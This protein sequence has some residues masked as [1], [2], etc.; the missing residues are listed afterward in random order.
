VAIVPL[1]PGLPVIIDAIKEIRRILQSP[2]QDLRQS[3]E[4][5]GPCSLAD[6]LL[7][8]VLRYVAS[9]VRD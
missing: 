5:N 8:H 3:L 7:N 4:N 6:D 9:D 2:G 1:M